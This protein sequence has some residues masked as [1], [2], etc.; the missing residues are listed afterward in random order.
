MRF[1]QS[2]FRRDYREYV[3]RG[4][5]CQQEGRW[6]AAR[7]EY[8]KALERLRNQDEFLKKQIE[9]KLWN[10]TLR[11]AGEYA[12]NGDA[13]TKDQQWELAI[14]TYQT[15]KDLYGESAPEIDEIQEKL[16]FALEMYRE[17]SLD[18]RLRTIGLGDSLG[19]GFAKLR[20]IK[21][22][23]LYQITPYDDRF[24]DSRHFTDK[25]L[26]DLKAKI[27]LSPEDPDL[28]F[29]LGITYARYGFLSEAM[30]EMKLVIQIHPTH[31]EAHFV[32]GNLLSDL[33]DLPQSIYF[34]E[35]SILLDPNLI[36]AYHCLGD[37]YEKSQDLA[38]AEEIYLKSLKQDPKDYGHEIAQIYLAL[39]SLYKKQGKY[40][41]ALAILQQY[42][43]QDEDNEEIHSQLGKIYMFMGDLKNASRCWKRVIMLDPESD[44]AKE[45]KLGL[46]GFANL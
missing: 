18:D 43:T 35:K 6:F 19:V 12:Q 10:V 14:E 4:D 24:D 31:A 34:L 3:K 2:I 23:G 27:K 25:Q 5:L 40:S 22:F 42:L 21:N 9:E 16:E 32:L 46:K 20:R 13:Y 39:G 26:A 30:E 37:L 44:L 8:R 45:A 29:D 38:K 1:F 15:A 36:P 28:H 11:L 7:V 33:G 17:K 41:Q